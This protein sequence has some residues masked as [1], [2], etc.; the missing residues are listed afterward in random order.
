[1]KKAN[2]SESSPM[3]RGM[4]FFGVCLDS[5]NFE[6]HMNCEDSFDFYD[7]WTKIIAATRPIF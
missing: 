2:D 3:E 6:V 5:K 7:F 4:L 1:M